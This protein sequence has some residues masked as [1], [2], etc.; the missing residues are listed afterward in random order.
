MPLDQAGLNGLGRYLF[1][2]P[3]RHTAVARSV[4]GPT[5]RVGSFSHQFSERD[6]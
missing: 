6:D 4:V 5:P 3:H 2:L 1:E